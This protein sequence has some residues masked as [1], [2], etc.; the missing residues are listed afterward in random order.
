M[1]RSVIL[2]YSFFSVFFGDLFLYML[3]SIYLYD[4]Y[5][6]WDVPGKMWIILF[7]LNLL[8]LFLVY[9][10]IRSKAPRML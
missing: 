6:I 7:L 1:S 10:I 9:M 8:Q 3:N 5:W 4:A 2:L